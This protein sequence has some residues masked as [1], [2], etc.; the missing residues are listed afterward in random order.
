MAVIAPINAQTFP[1]GSFLTNIN[2]SI[3]DL[4]RPYAWTEDQAK[5]LVYDLKRIMSGIHDDE[6]VPQHFFGT[7][8]LL[9][10][11]GARFSIIDGQQR[12]TTVSL[13]LGLIQTSIFRVA[14]D[15]E[16]KGGAAGPQV[17]HNAKELAK[18]ITPLLRFQGA[19]DDVTGKIQE[20]LRIL[21]SPEI[22]KTYESFLSG[23]DGKVDEEDNEPAEN[24]RE[25]AK[26]FTKN[27]IEEK[28]NFTGEP[29]AKLRYL[30]KVHDAVRQGLLVV[31]LQTSSSDA[32]YDLFESLNARG[33]PLNTLDLIK[34]WMLNKL[35]GEDST[36]VA[37]AMRKLSSD[38]VDD[39][40]EFFKD[41]YRARAL[42]NTENADGKA[43][44]L[45]AREYVFKDPIFVTQNFQSTLSQ[46]I[47]SE[48]V[49]MERW[50]PLWNSIVDG[51][52]PIAVQGTAAE[53]GWVGHRYELLSSNLSHSGVLTPLMMVASDVLRTDI[54]KFSELIHSVELF[55]FRYKTMC[56]GPVKNIEEAYYKFIQALTTNA[57]IDMTV[58]K[59][60]LQ[61]LINQHADDAKFESRLREKLNYSSGPAARA[62]IMYFL[63]TLECYS[64]GHAV[65]KKVQ[66]LGDWHLE[67]I[68]PQ[69][70]AGSPQ[71]AIT[72]FVDSIGN[73]CLLDP[74]INRQLSN[75]DFTA[76]RA[77]VAELHTAGKKLD[78]ADS[79]AVFQGPIL[80]WDVQEIE[81]RAQ[82]LMTQA[83]KVFKLA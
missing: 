73:L 8:V 31:S 52:I 56:G 60:T 47:R 24:L 38:D 59:Q 4:Q 77:K 78:C 6:S 64:Y 1:I 46:R 58:V 49:L 80:N 13:L 66:N 83:K 16:H 75:L 69:N 14:K 82:R 72:D 23:G 68:A 29:L 33:L 54:A 37:A 76:K 67:H 62:K 26:F 30:K 11:Q 3:P 15:A 53:R 39:Q 43:L 42:R 22:R 20:E 5:E 19:M 18:E 65:S 61:T 40:L 55:F 71:T 63:W 81:N 48:V 2:C 41:F 51:Q 45:M 35:S 34:V 74:K 70:P 9:S 21:V 79:L 10:A 12:L 57:D 50:T 28:I 25:I 27:L 17:A 7:I 44:A 32:G 36:D